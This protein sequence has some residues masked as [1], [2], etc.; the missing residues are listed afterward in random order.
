MNLVLRILGQPAVLRFCHESSF[1]HLRSR[2]NSNSWQESAASSNDHRMLQLEWLA[3]A[4][5]SVWDADALLRKG[6]FHRIYSDGPLVMHV[7]V[8]A[9]HDI[10]SSSSFSFQHLSGRCL[11]ASRLNEMFAESSSRAVPPTHLV[12]GAM[13]RR[14]MVYLP[15]KV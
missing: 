12:V 10:G 1:E 11:D 7:C 3:C 9:S 14:L 4:C 15:H 8:L 6:P 2:G 5:R 13:R